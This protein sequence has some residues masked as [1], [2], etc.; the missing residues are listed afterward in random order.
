MSHTSLFAANL[1]SSQVCQSLPAGYVL[2]PLAIDDYEKGFIEA[3]SHLT[4]VG[5]HS[6]ATFLERFSYIKAHNHEYFTIVIE[7]IKRAKIMAAGTVFVER[8]FIRGNGLVGHIEDIVVHKEAR[9]LQFGRYIIEALKSI[10]A[11][12]GCY[13]IILDCSEKNVPFYVKCGFKQKEVEM[14]W[15]IP[16]DAARAK[17]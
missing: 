3:L 2:R 15:Y 6:K 17:L 8:K 10:G 7:D 12:V 14:A 4:E 11:N 1:I 13:K 9:G 16:A 5:Q